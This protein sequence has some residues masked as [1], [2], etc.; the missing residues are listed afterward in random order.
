MIAGSATPP[1]YYSF[2]CSEL[3]AWRYFYLYFI[4]GFCITTL[5]I[6]M[7]PYFDRN[8]FNALRSTLFVITGL[9]NAVPVYH[10]IYKIEP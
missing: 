2:A 7:I 5:C 6:M 1:I 4:W 8:E 10:I 9:A 3:E